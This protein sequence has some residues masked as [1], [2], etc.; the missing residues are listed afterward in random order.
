MWFGKNELRLVKRSKK[1]LRLG[2]GGPYTPSKYAHA[3]NNV[4]YK[5]TYKKASVNRSQPNYSRVEC[6]TP[7]K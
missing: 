1:F 7:S 5:Q 6:Q 2:R 3:N 4:G